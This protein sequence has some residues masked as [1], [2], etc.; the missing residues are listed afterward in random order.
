[1]MPV[2]KSYRGFTL[3]ELL[4]V[5]AIIA[6]L[7][8]LLLPAVQSAREA[9]RRAQCVNNLKQIGLGLHNYH[10]TNNVLPYGTGVCCTPAGG[11]WT[12]FILPYMEQIQLYNALNQNLG[13]NT[14]ANRS[15]CQT[16]ISTFVCPSDPEAA[17]PIMTRFAAHNVN[18]A[19]ALWYPASM[20][21]THMDQCPFC[22]NQ[23]PSS[24]NFCCQGFNFGTNGN[25]ALGI[26]PGTFAGMFGRTSRAIGFNEIPDG[27]SNTIAVG[28]TL[29]KQCTF[30]GVF[31]QNF[32]L[33]GTMIPLNIMETAV[34]SNWFRTCGYKS[35][36]P[37]G[38]NFLFGDGST[39]FIKRTINYQTYNALGTRAGG[40]IISSDSL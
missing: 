24:T 38:G 23:T 39:R 2:R 35:M 27:L 7:I 17:Q 37:G 19:L 14:V 26:S 25:T 31:S 8:S 12:T 34:D 33:S 21:P 10:Q 6:V 16:V 4:V 13:Y 29:P 3:I 11:N 5:I 18:P 15:I 9:A 28:E 32:P 20:G 1:M 40:E 30:M 36:H 22:P